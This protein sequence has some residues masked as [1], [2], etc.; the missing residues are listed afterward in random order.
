M[1]TKVGGLSPHKTT[2]GPSPNKMTD[3]KRMA[4]P[5]DDNEG[6]AGGEASAQDGEDREDDGL[7][8]G[9]EEVD[10]MQDEATSE[11]PTRQK[12]WVAIEDQ[13]TYIL[14]AGK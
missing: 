12:T 14:A 5:E 6:R 3:Q 8:H 10:E 7:S 9:E 11:A 4:L 13:K 2:R 1:P